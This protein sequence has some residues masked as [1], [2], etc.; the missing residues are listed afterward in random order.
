MPPLFGTRRAPQ[1]SSSCC[2]IE[3]LRR[4]VGQAAAAHVAQRGDIGVAMQGG[5]PVVM[6]TKD[7]IQVIHLARAP[8]DVWRCILWRSSWGTVRRFVG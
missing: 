3:S 7:A 8:S 4:P 1:V 5:A 2:P 6:T